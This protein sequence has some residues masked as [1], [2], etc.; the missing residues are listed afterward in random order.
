M[1]LTF[2]LATVISYGPDDRTVTQ[3]AV[4]IIPSERSEDVSAF[5]CWDGPNVTINETVAG[6]IYAFMKSHNVQ[7]VA[8]VLFTMG[9][10]H[11]E[12][13]EYPAGGECPTCTFW[14]GKQSPDDARRWRKLK[15][16]RIEKLGFQPRFWSM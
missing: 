10:P 5:A 12:G 14:K 3:L 9:C 16:L 11:N 2:P 13:V 1:K 7:T 6:E 8:T 15:G 4:G